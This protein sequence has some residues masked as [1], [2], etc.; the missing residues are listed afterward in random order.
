MT[1][2][3]R[4]R[5]RNTAVDLFS[6]KWYETVPVAEICREAGIS[7]G[8]FYRYY[9]N[10]MELVTEI[11]DTFL[12]RFSAELAPVSDVTSFV[13][14]VADVALTH[15]PE[16]SVFREGQYRLTGYEG[17]LRNLY[18]ETLRRIYGRMCT[19]AE[20]LYAV[21]GLRF[22]STR[23][24]YTGRTFDRTLVERFLSLG[25][26]PG[27]VSVGPRNDICLPVEDRPFDTRSRLLEAGITMFGRKGYHGVGVSDVVRAAG[28]SVGT[29]Y[30]HF[31]SK[32]R[33]LTEIIDLIGRR[34]RR[35]LSREIQRG[36]NRLQQELDGYACFI[37]F[38]GR[39]HEYY[40]IVREAEFVAAEAVR[41][42]YDAFRRGYENN[43]TV[44]DEE[45]RPVAAE[46]LMGLA[47]YLGIEV[48]FSNRIDRVEPVLKEIGILLSRGIEGGETG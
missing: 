47:H 5:I 32:E 21:S 8:L 2:D 48:I 39:H 7:N 27:A 24:L 13:R 22:L 23:A 46:F 43:L 10:K 30:I 16:V 9:R 12:E 41:D 31:E 37:L 1:R 19:E 18:M 4:E 17:R 36:A 35:H 44:L 25:V 38:F 3:T 26:F 20:Y 42:Y 28:L 6:R 45:A 34:T 11:L 29:F 15:G 40:Q 33:F 14:V